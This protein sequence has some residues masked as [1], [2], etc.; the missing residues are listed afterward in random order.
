MPDVPVSDRRSYGQL[1]G[2]YFQTVSV[3]V[4]M[5]DRLDDEELRHRRAYVRL[6]EQRARLGD[7]LDA[8]AREWP[9]TEIERLLDEAFL[10]RRG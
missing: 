4:T 8:V 5:E 9:A 1:L 7:R 3:L 6:H 10:T 2:D